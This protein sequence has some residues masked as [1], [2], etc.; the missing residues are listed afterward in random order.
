MGIVLVVVPG[1]TTHSPAGRHREPRAGH[2]RHHILTTKAIC[3]KLKN[4]N[5]A[6]RAPLCR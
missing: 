1:A 2:Y 3:C 5:G 6:L 4:A